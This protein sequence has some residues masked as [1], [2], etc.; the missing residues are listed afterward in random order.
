[1]KIEHLGTED[2]LGRQITRIRLH[3][4]KE[5][6]GPVEVNFDPT[7]VEEFLR[8]P[9]EPGPDGK[10]TLESFFPFGQGRLHYRGSATLTEAEAA[11][12]REWMA[13]YHLAQ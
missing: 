13:K 6:G 8:T 5:R 3:L 12:L 11:D 9:A 4:A 7:A 2:V 10:L 1:M